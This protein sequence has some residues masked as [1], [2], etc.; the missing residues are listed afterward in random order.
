MGTSPGIGIAAKDQQRIFDRFVQL[1]AGTTRSHLGHGLGLSISKALVDLLQGDI[2][3]V[4]TPGD[5]TLFT[6]TIPPHSLLDDD[7]SFSEAGNLFIFSDL[8]EA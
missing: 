8:R 7:D 1:D 3:L 6:V 4:S 5:G 2:S